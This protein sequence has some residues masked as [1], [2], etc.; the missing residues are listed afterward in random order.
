MSLRTPLR[1]TTIWG[2]LLLTPVLSPMGCGGCQGQA[3][4]PYVSP[5]SLAVLEVPSL[6]KAMVANLGF[7]DR[8]A[9]GSLAQT[10]IG[11]RK[12]M[13]KRELDLDLK[14]AKSFQSKGIDPRKGL[15]F[16]L[17][18]EGV[19][20][21]VMP[22]TD[23]KALDKYL[24]QQLTRHSSGAVSFTD[25][26]KD[27][28][29]VTLASFS[30]REMGGWT[31]RSKHLIAAMPL[32]G[33]ADEGIA[34]KLAALTKLDKSIDQN[35]TF[36]A[37]RK[38][39]ARFDALVYVDG[40]AARAR[41]AKRAKK[42]QSFASSQL[43]KTIDDEREL[44]EGLLSYV[45]G[46]SL[47]WH[48]EHSRVE[49]KGLLSVP[50]AKRAALREIL[51][52]EGKAPPLARYIGEKAL[53]VGRV[54]LSPKGL[55]DRSL[56]LLAPRQKR[57]VYRTIERWEQSNNLSFS[58][59]IL[60]V[61]AGRYAAAVFPPRATQGGSPQ[62]TLR[63][64]G[65]VG[66]AQVKDAKQ[67]ATLLERLERFLVVNRHEVRTRSKGK[68]KVFHLSQ[69]GQEILS[70]S[71]AGKMLLVSTPQQ[72]EPTVALIEKGGRHIVDHVS[73]P[74]AKRLLKSD[75][76]QVLYQ[77]LAGLSVA[78]KK[79]D[80]PMPLRLVMIPALDTLDK[81]QD[82]TLGAEVGSEGIRADLILRVR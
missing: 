41:L 80:L 1:A 8:V 63:S 45:D 40:A 22:T 52:G 24:R 28:V 34:A 58:K 5:K 7:I 38:A 16:S 54:S 51:S 14:D 15:V 47:A 2:L 66:M 26:A 42:M 10:L 72:L 60:G 59:D 57:R 25:Q 3:P 61:F 39:L 4:L 19:L 76:G 77:D 64:L 9:K 36:M 18:D 69:G 30:G 33:K 20:A 62:Q 11:G 55:F 75:E 17:D 81:L 37:A 67:A 13:I 79:V 35:A 43:K 53:L 49:L 65:V 23:A 46:L 31:F 21:L 12:A 29:K 48:A 68:R 73:S 56:Q 71:L 50:K 6:H 82:V 44:G 74:R 78:L 32:E 27:G 70:W